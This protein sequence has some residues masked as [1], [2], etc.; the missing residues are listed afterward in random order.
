MMTRKVL[1]VAARM[2]LLRYD[3]NDKFWWWRQE[4]YYCDDESTRCRWTDVR[5]YMLHANVQVPQHVGIVADR[6]IAVN[7]EAVNGRHSL[8]RG[9]INRRVFGVKS[10][11]C[12]SASIRD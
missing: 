7:V 11:Q 9:F 5:L 8:C 4:S 10:R 12:D 6:E 2:L 1:V 3:G